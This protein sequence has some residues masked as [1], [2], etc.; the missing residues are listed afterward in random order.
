MVKI[1]GTGR[2]ILFYFSISFHEIYLDDFFNL[3]DFFLNSNNGTNSVD[4]PYCNIVSNEVYYYFKLI[5][6]LLYRNIQ[7]QMYVSLFS[8]S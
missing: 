7:T 2:T 3:M 8:L 5:F 1:P 4:I 6:V